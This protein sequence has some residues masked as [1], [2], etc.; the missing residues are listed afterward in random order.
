MTEI[1]TVLSS[2]VSI[3]S[4]IAVSRLM[5]VYSLDTLSLSADQYKL[6]VSEPCED[7]STKHISKFVPL[8][9]VISVIRNQFAIDKI[10][11]DI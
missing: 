4:S 2:D 9:D 8:G 6:L 3:L 10:S 1:I 7:T 11:D 5:P